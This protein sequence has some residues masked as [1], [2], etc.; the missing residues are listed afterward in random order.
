MYVAFL[1]H[2]T[3]SVRL[4]AAVAAL[5]RLSALRVLSLRLWY[6]GH[7]DPPDAFLAALLRGLRHLTYSYEGLSVPYRVLGVHY[8]DK[9]EVSSFAEP[10][11]KPLQKYQHYLMTLQDFWS[12]ILIGYDASLAYQ[13]CLDAAA[14]TI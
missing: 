1:E 8:L 7:G 6:P 9:L 2:Q 4:T 3:G 11:R 14:V 13:H 10:G 12:M 5:K